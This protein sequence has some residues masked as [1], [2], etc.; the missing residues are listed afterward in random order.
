VFALILA[1]R[2]FS[3]VSFDNYTVVILFALVLYILNT[4]VKP[5]LILL[6]LPITIISLGIF[7]LIINA[8][9]VYSAAELV[10]GIHIAGF[11]TAFWFALVYS[12]I[13]LILESILINE[14][15]IKIKVER[16]K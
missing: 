12:F 9:I 13:K 10:N 4:F 5:L 16:Y 6:T 1:D 2:L 11:W 15:K 7:L 3:S 8:L 14:T